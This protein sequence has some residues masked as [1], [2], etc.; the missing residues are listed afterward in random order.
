M[1]RTI[2]E[3]ISRWSKEV[4]EKPNKHLGNFSACPYARSCRKNKQFKIE[5]V[6]EAKQ[7]LPTV[8]DWANK[9][10]RTKYRIA[11]IGC[12][13]LSITATQLDSSIEALNFVYMPKDVYL[14]ASHPETG[15]D[16]ID[17]LYDH[18]FE[19]STDFSMVLIQ[20]YQDLEEASQKLKKVGYY[21][22]WEADYYNETVG[23]RHQ[24]KERINLMRGMK[25]TAKKV[26]GK[27]NPMLGKAKKK[28]KKKK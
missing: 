4:I 24:L 14:M 25:K 13:D 5:E 2:T 15:D 9:L 27:K 17:F 3:D 12:S 11:I 7:L 20:R 18:G 22:Y 1:V 6:H 19:T 8:V 28:K 16:N 10:K 23:H 21:K 26:N